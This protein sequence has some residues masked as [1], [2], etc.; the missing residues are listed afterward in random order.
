MTVHTLVI[1]RLSSADRFARRLL[2][3]MVRPAGLLDEA[4]VLRRCAMYRKAFPTSALSFPASVL[5]SGVVADWIRRHG[6]SVDIASAEELDLAVSREVAAKHLVMH[7]RADTDSAA[8]RRAAAAG[9]IKFV[10]GAEEHLAMLGGST[11][12]VR[13]VIVD[14]GQ[15]GWEDHAAHV[16]AQRA[17]T[18]IG[19]HGELL[20]SDGAGGADTVIEMVGAMARLS[21]RHGAILSRLSLGG[22]SEEPSGDIR[23][24]RGVAEETAEVIR[25]GCALCRYPVPALTVSL[26][27]L[28]LA[29]AG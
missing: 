10:V 9:V 21:R 12:A 13:Q 29:A 4:V 14:S 26:T 6:V 2:D 20:R 17:T 27:P 16:V 25:D 24:L 8:V 11:G 18:L 19:V 3:D 22:L 7:C 28:A 23:V 1:P 5:R 15:P